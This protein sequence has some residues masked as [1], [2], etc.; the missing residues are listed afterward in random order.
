MISIISFKCAW[1]SF[2]LNVVDTRLVLPF[3][4]LPRHIQLPSSAF[5]SR[6]PHQLPQVARRPAYLCKSEAPLDA[7]QVL[8]GDFVAHDVALFAVVQLLPRASLV[9]AHHCD[10]D[11]PGRLADAQAQVAVVRVDIATLLEGLDDLDD[12]LEDGVVNVVL[13]EFSEELVES[14]C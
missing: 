7:L 3:P 6:S 14:V 11:G 1:V 13:F 4:F 12:G 10:A 5:P 9:D 8:A 2:Y